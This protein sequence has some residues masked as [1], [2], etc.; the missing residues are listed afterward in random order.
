M[1]P[2]RAQVK[3]R[4]KSAEEWAVIMPEENGHAEVH[5]DHKIIGI[6]PGQAAVFYDDEICL[7]GGI[8]QAS[9]R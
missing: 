8:I 3:I 1:K 2:I 9:E 6:T 5:F 4:Y 7:G